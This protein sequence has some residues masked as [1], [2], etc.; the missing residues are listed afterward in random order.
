MNGQ[1]HSYTETKKMKFLAT[2]ARGR[3]KRKLIGDC[4][5]LILLKR[6]CDHF[7]SILR[8]S[9]IRPSIH[10]FKAISSSP[11]LLRGAPDTARITVSE[12]HAEAPQATA[13]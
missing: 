13:S 6:I 11:L 12:L 8:L 2:F 10:S 1:P 5:S 9:L 7:G 4:T 3:L